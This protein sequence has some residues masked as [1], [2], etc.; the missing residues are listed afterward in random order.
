MDVAIWLGHEFSSQDEK[1]KVNLPVGRDTAPLLKVVPSETND[2]M[3][4]VWVLMA[5]T[6]TLPPY[7]WDL[8]TKAAE[9]KT[10]HGPHREKQQMSGGE[11][12]M[13]DV[14]GEYSD[15]TILEMH[16]SKKNKGPNTYV[17]FAAL[18]DSEGSTLRA[19]AFGQI[20][21]FKNAKTEIDRVDVAHPYRGQGLCGS[22][23]KLVFDNFL[24]IRHEHLGLNHIGITNWGGKAGEKCYVKA[25]RA[26]GYTVAPEDP[27]HPEDYH[28]LWKSI[29]G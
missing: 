23:M 27:N 25:A 24:K 13:R 1:S 5:S 22:L 17:W 19:C 2:D 3:Q 26:A 8:I 9:E 18:L 20:K 4:K 21:N 28:F 29:K 15:F 10:F 11:W 16:L 6:D 14:D 7:L 12:V